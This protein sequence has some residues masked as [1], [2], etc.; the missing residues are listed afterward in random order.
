MRLL[1][2][3]IRSPYFNK[4]VNILSFFQVIEKHHPSFPE[5]KLE[6]EKVS[7]LVY[8]KGKYDDV[9]MRGL[10]SDTLELIEDFLAHQNMKKQGFSLD[11]FLLNELNSRNQDILSNIRSKKMEEVGSSI[12]DKYYFLNRYLISYEINNIKWKENDSKKEKLIGESSIEMELKK[13]N[14]FYAYEGMRYLNRMSIFKFV[15]VNPDE[16]AAQRERMLS[17]C[18]ELVGSS[19]VFS[20]LKLFQ[21][22]AAMDNRS[23]FEELKTKLLDHI[24]PCLSRNDIM[25]GLDL[26]LVYCYSQSSK[27]VQG[28]KE[29]HKASFEILKKYAELGLDME[30]G[31]IEEDQFSSLVIIAIKNQEF[32]WAKKYVLENDK[33]LLKE[34]RSDTVAYSLGNIAEV[35]GNLK[36]ALFQLNQIMKPSLSQSLN[37]RTLLI[38]IYY[39]KGDMKQVL[40]T[41][42]SFN[43]FLSTNTKLSDFHKKVYGSL[44]NNT[45]LLAKLNLGS[46]KMDLPKWIEEME[47]KGEMI[48][49]GWVI[50]NAK[51]LLPK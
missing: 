37:I 35:E 14:E 39:K 32:E 17:I 40:Q 38:K 5:N 26:L 48:I 23:A 30:N 15:F 33:N 20:Y 21:E 36:E 34:R 28:V 49:K 25:V 11:P 8:G 50:R 7:Q 13:L 2:E 41:C 10:L 22:V 1:S 43:K 47:T 46:I 45:I 4:N 31:Y 18:N 12:H 19:K 29:I 9:R 16:F 42:K 51:E 27:G 3:F 44:V 6:K 24:D